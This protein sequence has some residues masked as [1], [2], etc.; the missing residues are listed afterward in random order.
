[1]TCQWP[2]LRAIKRFLMVEC[3]FNGHR[4]LKS[5]RCQCIWLIN[6]TPAPWREMPG[7]EMWA[8]CGCGWCIICDRLGFRSR[9][10]AVSVSVFFPLFTGGWIPSLPERKNC[11]R[12]AHQEWA[13]HVLDAAQA[14]HFITSS[15][16]AK[17]HCFLLPADLGCTLRHPASPAPPWWMC[18][19]D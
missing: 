9:T 15:P 4:R 16:S 12:T 17:V 1:M 2:V 19:E 5:H 13:R 6:L 7:V 3:S 11:G 10:A 8:D 18:E 14:Q